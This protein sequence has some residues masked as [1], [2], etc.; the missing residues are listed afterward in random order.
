MK[1][2]FIKKF[3]IIILWIAILNIFVSIFYGFFFANDFQELK[4][5]IFFRIKYYSR[6][7]VSINLSYNDIK[8]NKNNVISKEN[9]SVKIT[10]INYD[11]S[12]GKL[13]LNLEFY[14][15][16][17]QNLE[18]IM[19]ML[20]ICD[21]K[22]VFYN[23]MLGIAEMVDNIDYLVYTQKLYNNFDIKKLN[24]MKIDKEI[25]GTFYTS[26]D[27]NYKNIELKLDLDANYEFSNELSIK[28]LDLIY[29]PA[30][31]FS[32]KP[33]EPLGEFRFTIDF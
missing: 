18:N 26:N 3:L 5:E 6:E 17:G 1:I 23:D 10:D 16:D 12:S 33:I 20:R 24:I 15:N 7:I 30:G 9:I 25:N 2:S 28:L 27:E 8:D 31:D 29:T 11:Q 22:N 14:T 21:S 13:K 4:D 32:Y 19:C